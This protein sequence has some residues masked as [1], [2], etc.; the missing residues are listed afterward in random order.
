MPHATISALILAVAT[1]YASAQSP[2]T[3]P[4]APIW[5]LSR[6]VYPPEITTEAGY[7]D[8][9]RSRREHY[10]A[11]SDGP[12]AVN[13]TL[14]WELEPFASRWLLGLG[15]A[16]E[17]ATAN[18]LLASAIERLRAEPDTAD[19]RLVLDPLLPFAVALE[20]IW[21]PGEGEVTTLARRRG[22]M[23]LAVLLE[24]E[25][26]D[27]TSAALLWQAVLYREMGRPDKA[28][29]LLPLATARVERDASA[30]QFF[31]RL[32]RCRVLADRGGYA[33][34]SALLLQVE[35]LAHDW[36]TDEHAREEATHAA[37]LVRM[38]VIEQW[39]NTLDPAV[40]DR[41]VAWC[42]RAIERIRADLPED[43]V[44]LFRLGQAVPFVEPLPDT[45]LAKPTT[46]PVTNVGRNDP[47]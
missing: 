41:E 45:P 15:T 27:V 44:E 29:K 35:E 33:A 14:A 4:V 24:H 5:E 34:A 20:A 37:M 10:E 18:V 11:Q 42:T 32:L 8:W 16:Q 40:N 23:G 47:E 22:V 13:L 26:A 39:R 1:P 6:S 30:Y 21:N 9:A 43:R 3:Q 25:R 2:A 7:L 19:S 46:R 38:R 31:A 28:L 12:A 17:Q 36:F